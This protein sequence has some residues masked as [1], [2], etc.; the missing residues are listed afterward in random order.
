[1]V[2]RGVPSIALFA[3]L[4]LSPPGVVAGQAAPDTSQVTFDFQ[5]V[6]I[7]AVITAMAEAG[8]LNVSFG[9]LPSK[10]VTLRTSQPVPRDG[11]RQL[12]ESVV[13]SNGLT[14][15]DDNGLLR[16]SEPEPPA[17]STPRTPVTP[18]RRSREQEDVPLEFYVYR[19]KHAEAPEMASTLQA[20]FG[21]T[22]MSSGSSPLRSTLS[23]QLRSQR[24]QPGNPDAGGVQRQ[25]LVQAPQSSNANDFYIVADEMSNSLLIRARPAGWDALRQVVDTLD[26][27]PLQTLIEATIVEVRRSATTRLDVSTDIPLQLH[28]SGTE[29]GGQIGKPATGDAVLKVLGLGSISADIVMSASRSNAN[30]RVLSRPLIV[31]QNNYEARILIGSQRPFV[32][33]VRALPTES[34]VR[35]QVVQYRDVGTSLSIRPTISSDGHVALTIVE[36]VSNATSETQFGAP[37]ISSRE[38]STRLVLN[39]GQTAVIGGLIDYTQEDVRSGVPLLRDIPLLGLLFGSTTK[40][41]VQTELFLFLTPHVVR[42]D[43]EAE[44][45]RQQLEDAAKMLPRDGPVGSLIRPDTTGIGG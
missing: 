21:G 31:A 39:D 29:L 35:D 3:C 45:L 37:V 7:R 22:V 24:I 5:N 8:D 15:T 44:R 4:L 34:A 40:T 1:M 6:D 32:Q 11:V 19:L 14:L 38:A 33:V 23:D 28:S 43:E 17:P 16:V 30:I 10:T 2:T 41:R 36:E 9:S 42:T 25:A 13:T 26:V 12:L 18:P 27:R 20:L